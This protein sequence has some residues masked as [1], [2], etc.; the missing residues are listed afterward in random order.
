MFLKFRIYRCHPVD[1]KILFLRL[2]C[3]A[4]Q[5]KPPKI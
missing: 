5:E 4:L 1:P 3:R 2:P